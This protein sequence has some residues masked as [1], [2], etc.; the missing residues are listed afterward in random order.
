MPARTAKLVEV[1]WLAFG[2]ALTEYM[3]ENGI[4]YREME[5]RSGVSKSNLSRVMQG[6]PLMTDA[7]LSLCDVA[8]IEA[9]HF[10]G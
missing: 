8:E 4:S 10:A 6:K 7:Y 5:R 3:D 1:D 2:R 9:R